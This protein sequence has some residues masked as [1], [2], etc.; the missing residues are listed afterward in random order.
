MVHGEGRP[1]VRVDLKYQVR[2]EL[3]WFEQGGGPEN[4]N[5]ET[6]E[7]YE[8]GLEECRLRNGTSRGDS[9]VEEPLRSDWWVV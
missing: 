6:E 7:H 3:V 1:K 5:E 8:T 4:V 2:E 9:T